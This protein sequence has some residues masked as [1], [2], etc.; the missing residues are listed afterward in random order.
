[1]SRNTCPHCSGLGAT[2]SFGGG[3]ACLLNPPIPC[4]HCNGMGY[5]EESDPIACACG[6][7]NLQVYHTVLDGWVVYCPECGFEV[8]G[9]IDRDSAVEYWNHKN[10]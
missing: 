6:N 4:S 8:S 10:S 1:M 2:P 5:I 3:K 7:H 9:N